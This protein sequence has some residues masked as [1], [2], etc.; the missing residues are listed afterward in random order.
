MTDATEPDEAVPGIYIHSDAEEGRLLYTLDVDGETFAVSCRDGGFDYDWIS[1][2]NKGYG[3]G[4]SGPAQTR[5]RPMR[6]AS[7]RSS[8]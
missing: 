2:P 7:G 8:G 4:S 6:R 5:G 1:G 3:V